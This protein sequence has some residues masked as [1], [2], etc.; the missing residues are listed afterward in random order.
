MSIEIQRAIAVLRNDVARRLGE[1]V[2]TPARERP[3]LRGQ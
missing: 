1:P 2:L 3:K